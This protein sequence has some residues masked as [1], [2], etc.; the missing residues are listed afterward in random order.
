MA[1]Q[2][3][4]W[5]TRLA[6]EKADCSCLRSERMRLRVCFDER[7]RGLR[8]EEPNRLANMLTEGATVVLVALPLTYVK[9]RLYQSSIVP[10]ML[11]VLK[12]WR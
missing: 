4:R 11:L 5:I 1:L 3:N 2:K 9:S 12:L 6:R 8:G 7:S 10:A